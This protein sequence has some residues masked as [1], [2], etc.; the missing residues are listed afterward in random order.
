MSILLNA[1]VIAVGQDSLGRQSVQVADSGGLR[2]LAKPLTGHQVAVALYN[3]T[4]AAATIATTASAVNLPSASSYTL[5]DLW[6]KAMT[7]T[8]GAI[9]APVPAHGTVLLRAHAG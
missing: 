5:T 7:H 4:A 1:D 8:A 9:S 2:V 3:E 6:S